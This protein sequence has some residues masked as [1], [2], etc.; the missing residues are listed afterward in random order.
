MRWKSNSSVSAA[1]SN[2]VPLRI[3]RKV[4]KSGFAPS[5]SR[6][7]C[8]DYQIRKNKLLAREHF[9]FSVILTLNE[10]KGKNLAPKQRSKHSQRH[11]FTKRPFPTKIDMFR[12]D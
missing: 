10:V 4:L 11:M 8:A 5:A 1:A 9:A 3:T 2:I 7:V 6:T 12:G